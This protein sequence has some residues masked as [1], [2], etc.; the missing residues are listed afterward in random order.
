MAFKG[1]AWVT[2]EDTKIA[3][4][5]GEHG[6]RKWSV[7]ADNLPGRNGKQVRARCGTPVATLQCA[8]M[9]PAVKLAPWRIGACSSNM[10]RTMQG[11]R[12]AYSLCRSTV[13]SRRAL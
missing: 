3:T 6:I 12:M 13:L 10:L 4:L 11:L 9:R 7:V 2:E 1:V 5:V 8:A